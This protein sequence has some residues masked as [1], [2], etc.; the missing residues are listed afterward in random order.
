MSLESSVPG[1]FAAGSMPPPASPPSQQLPPTSPPTLEEVHAE[2]GTQAAK[3]G[4]VEKLGKWAKIAGLV[5][6]GGLA[7][8]A[9]MATYSVTGPLC[10]AA[11][12]VLKIG[13]A[14]MIKHGVRDASR[15]KN[16][17]DLSYNALKLG[18][19]PF[20]ALLI[21]EKTWGWKPPMFEKEQPSVFRKGPIVEYEP[22]QPLSPPVVP[23]S[24]PTPKE[25]E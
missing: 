8:G 18:I 11:S 24:R 3:K 14:R 20:G 23:P 21:A 22:P 25:N 12:L 9:Y 15:I 13:Q 2:L 1:P 17:G 10:L 5:I 16:V 4:T 6:G 19:L 7:I